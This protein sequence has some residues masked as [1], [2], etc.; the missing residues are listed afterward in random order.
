MAYILDLN[1]FGVID[2]KRQFICPLLDI[3]FN[4]IMYKLNE[5][6][7]ENDILK[8]LSNLNLINRKILRLN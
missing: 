7:N 8:M 3:I 5:G 1:I 4:G 2:F 6:L